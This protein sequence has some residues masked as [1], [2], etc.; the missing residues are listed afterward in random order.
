MVQPGF[1]YKMK[2]IVEEANGTPP[3]NSIRV[4]VIKKTETEPILTATVNMPPTELP[5]V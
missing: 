1:S 5:F 3:D 2:S 4:F